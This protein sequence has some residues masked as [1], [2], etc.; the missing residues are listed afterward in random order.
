MT[1]NRCGADAAIKRDN[2]YYCG[3]CA[4]E[5]DWG[6]IIAQVQ[7]GPHSSE[8]VVFDDRSE[9]PDAA[10]ASSNGSADPFTS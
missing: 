10:V 2:A 3:R 5:R 4:V 8:K 9:D 6:E 7:D 1:C